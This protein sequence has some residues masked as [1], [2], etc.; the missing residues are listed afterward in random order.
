MKPYAS[1]I[2]TT[3]I[4]KAAKVKSKTGKAGPKERLIAAKRR[5]K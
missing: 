4:R 2:S 3:A 5:P 1:E